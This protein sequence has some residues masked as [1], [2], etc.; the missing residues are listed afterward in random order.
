MNVTELQEA[1]GLSGL[2]ADIVRQ[3]DDLERRIAQW[4]PRPCPRNRTP[5]RAAV[6]VRSVHRPILVAGEVW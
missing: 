2:D 1:L 3:A 6:Q 5:K 4:Q